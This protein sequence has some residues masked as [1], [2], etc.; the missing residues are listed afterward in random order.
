M[1]MITMEYQSWD[2]DELGNVLREPGHVDSAD[3]VEAAIIPYG[4]ARI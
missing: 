3:P 1:R 4:Y 2:M